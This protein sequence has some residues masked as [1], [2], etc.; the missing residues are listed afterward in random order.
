MT[1]MCE[2]KKILIINSQRVTV[3]TKHW[4]GWAS[5]PSAG[6]GHAIDAAWSAHDASRP[7][8]APFVTRGRMNGERRTRLSSTGAR[9]YAT[10]TRKTGDRERATAHA[11]TGSSSWRSP[12]TGRGNTVRVALNHRANAVERALDAEYCRYSRF[13]IHDPLTVGTL[14]ATC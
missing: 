14:M 10:K 12:T 9:Y 1:M 11:S 13:T 8:H 6:R 4:R 3:E 7:W 2:R 5:D